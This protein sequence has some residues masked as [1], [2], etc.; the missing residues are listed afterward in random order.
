MC[1]EVNQ[2]LSEVCGLR[3]AMPF[4]VNRHIENGGRGREG[5]GCRLAGKGSR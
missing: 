4:Q 1:F 3:A 5:A 2:G